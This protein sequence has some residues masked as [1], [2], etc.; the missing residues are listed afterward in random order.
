MAFYAV[1]VRDRVI[2]R[3]TQRYN[4]VDNKRFFL[5]EAVSD[6]TSMGKGQPRIGCDGQRRLW[7]LSPPSL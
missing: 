3:V 5:I 6:E 7:W 1:D 2:R 4:G